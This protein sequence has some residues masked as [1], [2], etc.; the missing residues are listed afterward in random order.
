MS[1]MV[2]EESRSSQHLPTAQHRRLL[3]SASSVLALR[4]ALTGTGHLVDPRLDVPHTQPIEPSS[5]EQRCD[6]PASKHFVIDVRCG[7]Q[8]R[9]HHLL[10]P[11]G[12]EFAE[13]GD[14]RGYRSL[15]CPLL[16]FQPLLMHLLASL[17]VDVL[18]LPLP[19][20][21]RDPRVG[22]ETG[23]P[24]RASGVDGAP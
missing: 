16:K 5:A 20:G 21:L 19:I 17:A 1:L 9:L 12:E 4:A 22:G 13:L 8:I 14:T 11:V 6:V 2:R 23:G 18:A 3:L 15:P 7:C 24:D 10:K